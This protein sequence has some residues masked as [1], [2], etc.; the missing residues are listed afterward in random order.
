MA[1]LCVCM[2]KVRGAYRSILL[3]FN[4]F[5]IYIESLR[6][7]GK[8]KE[9]EEGKDKD[10]IIGKELVLERELILIALLWS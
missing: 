4:T 7:V 5:N 1:V 6:L 3:L 10:K 9:S 2:R 8:A